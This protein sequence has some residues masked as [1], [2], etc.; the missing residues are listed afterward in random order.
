MFGSKGAFLQNNIETRKT[1]TPETFKALANSK[2][3]VPPKIIQKRPAPRI[4]TEMPV[5]DETAKEETVK[6]AD[7]AISLPLTEF[8]AEKGMFESGEAAAS[9]E[10]PMM[11]GSSPHNQ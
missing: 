2:E 3:H 10:E 1:Y 4:S 8:V 9:V 5:K 11:K 6:S 7:S